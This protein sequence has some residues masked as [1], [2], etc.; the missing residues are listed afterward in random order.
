MERGDEGLQHFECVCVHVCVQTFT[1]S[2]LMKHRG[3]L[4]VLAEMEEGGG[5]CGAEQ[6]Q[7]VPMEDI[8]SS[9]WF[10]EVWANVIVWRKEEEIGCHRSVMLCCTCSTCSGVQEDSIITIMSSVYWFFGHKSLS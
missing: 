3:V 9:C 2:R 8:R 6:G 7:S 5:S 10:V 4:D 1:G